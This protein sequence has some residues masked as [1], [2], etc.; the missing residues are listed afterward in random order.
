MIN[1]KC[2]CHDGANIF[3]SCFVPCCDR[4]GQPRINFMKDLLTRDLFREAVFERDNHKCVSCGK[5]AVDAHHIIERRLFS[6]GGYYLDNGAS[7][8]ENC[9]ILAEQTII[10]TET[11]RDF[12]KIKKVVLPEHLYKDHIYDKWGNAILPDGTRMRGELFYDESVQKV[13]KPVLSEFREFVK[14]P[15]TYHLPWSQ[16]ATD[17][18]RT[19]SNVD[20]FKGKEV[21]VTVKMDGENTTMYSNHIHARSVDSRHHVSRDWVKNFHSKIQHDIPVGWRICGENLWAKHSIKYCQLTSYFQVFSI[22]N[23]KNECLSWADT[24]EWSKLLNL[25]MVRTVY[26]GIFDEK[27]IRNIQ[28]P[29]DTDEGYVIRLADSFRY[30]DFKTSCGKFVRKN[31]VR[32]HGHWTNTHVEIN[33]L[34]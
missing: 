7:L 11:L 19:L 2:T 26:K 27:L 24:V 8:C 14:Y 25:T 28:L 5:H 29:F 17:D 3:C 1:C 16:S 23:E 4:D 18:D 13:L 21:V 30:R 33:E 22:W 9:H 6:D 31:H 32:T 10:H 12:C 20:C 34:L 15:R